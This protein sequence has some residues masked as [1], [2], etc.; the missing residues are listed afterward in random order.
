MSGAPVR[1]TRAMIA[2]MRPALMPG[3]YVFCAAPPD[4][5]EPPPDTLA[6]F[7]EDEGL[8]L[9]LPVEV[10]ESFGLGSGPA[11]RRITLQV[12]SDLEGIGLTAAVAAALTREGIPCNMIAALRHD[13]VFVPIPLAERALAA[14][15]RLADE[16][17]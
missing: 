7:R 12:H 16:A 5:A 1:E 6:S 10:A 11:M 2:G 13:H 14:L 3:A 9:L 17:R 15:E 8:S 4:M